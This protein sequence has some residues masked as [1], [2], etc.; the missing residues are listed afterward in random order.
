MRL[1]SPVEMS[2]LYKTEHNE[3]TYILTILE[4]FSWHD[5]VSVTEAKKV[6]INKRKKSFFF[7]H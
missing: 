4:P 1:S 7:L 2:L 6:P 3:I 5:F